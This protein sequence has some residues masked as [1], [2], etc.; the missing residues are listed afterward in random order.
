MN[1]RTTW[2]ASLNGPGASPSDNLLGALVLSPTACRLRHPPRV[3]V[4]VS[5]HLRGARESPMLRDAL[6]AVRQEWGAAVFVHTW[7]TDEASMSWRKLPVTA[8]SPVTPHALGDYLG[9]DP[10]GAACV[11]L[12]IKAVACKTVH[13]CA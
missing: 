2:R 9:F 4:L 11:A 3:A 1:T 8:A 12:G 6:L 7:K 5:G 10:E 13:A